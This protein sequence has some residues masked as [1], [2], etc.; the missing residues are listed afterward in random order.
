MQ[1][2]QMCEE[3]SRCIAQTQHSVFLRRQARPNGQVNSQ[4][5]NTAPTN[6][7][8]WMC[9]VSRTSIRGPIYSICLVVQIKM[10]ISRPDNLPLCHFIR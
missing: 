4:A 8:S 10:H 6:A 2:R 1:V 9:K 3:G 7:E 5:A